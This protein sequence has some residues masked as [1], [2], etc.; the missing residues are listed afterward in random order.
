M[1]YRCSFAREVKTRK[2]N[3]KNKSLFKYMHTFLRN[4]PRLYMTSI[5]LLYLFCMKIIRSTTYTNGFRN[6]DN[7]T[8][9]WVL[10]F[11]HSKSHKKCNRVV[12]GF[13]AA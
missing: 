9:Y 4:K 5:I 8:H 10:G 1:S 6:S 2:E 3:R 12:L 11:A 7:S 13:Y